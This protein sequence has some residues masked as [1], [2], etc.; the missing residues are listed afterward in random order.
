MRGARRFRWSTRGQK[1]A[2]LLNMSSK[3]A[4]IDLEPWQ[5]FGWGSSRLVLWG[6]Q[7]QSKQQELKEKQNHGAHSLVNQ[8]MATAIVGNDL[9]S[10]CLYVIGLTFASAGPLAPVCLVIT[11]A[12]LYLFRWVYTEAVGALPIDGGAYTIL[13]NSTSKAVAASAACLTLLSY[14]ATA[15]VS[16]TDAVIYLQS[17]WP[18]LTEIVGVL[19]LLALFCGLAILGV[20]ESAA[21]ASCM[22]SLH[23]AT[24]L[25]V[26]IIGI[27]HM[28]N[29]K[30]K[31]FSDNWKS[32]FPDIL[33]GD[34][35]D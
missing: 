26:A 23:M 18:E 25:L 24:L 20:G 32:P 29:D 33:A 28:A 35:D 1:Q 2:L 16:A 14:V 11:A 34:G 27:I 10:S 6:D 4:P 21:V 5:F 17:V 3:R 12:M 19:F 15:V 31:I 7:Q 9:L 30:G 13:L 22:L 8:W